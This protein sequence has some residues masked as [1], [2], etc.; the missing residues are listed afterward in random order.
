MSLAEF[1]D[2]SVLSA[3]HL[4][5]LFENKTFGTQRL[6]YLTQICTNE[7]YCSKKNLRNFQKR[8][9]EPQRK[10]VTHA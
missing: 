9:N 5:D 10:T 6:E 4:Y 3:E 1:S 2:E 8:L 7:F